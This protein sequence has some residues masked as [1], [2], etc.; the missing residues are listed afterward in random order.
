MRLKALIL[1]TRLRT[2]SLDCSGHGAAD[3]CKFPQRPHLCLC[4]IHDL[5]ATLL[6][7]HQPTPEGQS[8]DGREGEEISS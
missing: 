4:Q 5:D 2:K 1:K 8:G 6:L 7:L 3:A